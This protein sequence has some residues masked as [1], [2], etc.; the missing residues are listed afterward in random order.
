MKSEI[1]WWTRVVRTED[2]DVRKIM[3]DERGAERDQ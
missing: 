1:L 3:M 2:R